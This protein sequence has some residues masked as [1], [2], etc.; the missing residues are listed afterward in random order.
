MQL[1]GNNILS[2]EM[3]DQYFNMEELWKNIDNGTLYT[4]EQRA[5]SSNTKLQSE[6]LK[7]LEAIEKKKRLIFS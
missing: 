4:F 1:M 2:V 5:D 3:M 7:T 6:I